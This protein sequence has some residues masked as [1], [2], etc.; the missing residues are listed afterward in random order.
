MNEQKAAHSIY[1][2]VFHFVFK[3]LMSKSKKHVQLV[4][5]MRLVLLNEQRSPIQSYT[6]PSLLEPMGIDSVT[7]LRVVT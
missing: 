3:R 1:S 4:C 2:N 7:L 6:L 5:I